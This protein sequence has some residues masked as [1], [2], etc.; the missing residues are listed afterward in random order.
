MISLWHDRVQ[1]ASNSNCCIRIIY[2]GRL[3]HLAPKF[4]TCT[5]VVRKKWKCMCYTVGKFM[6]DNNLAMAHVFAFQQT[7]LW[8]Q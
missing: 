6:W 4:L 1:D 2:D 3:V 5:H 8:F 7:G